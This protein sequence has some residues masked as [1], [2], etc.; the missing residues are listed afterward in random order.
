MWAFRCIKNAEVRKRPE[1]TIIFEDADLIV[2]NK[3]SGLLTM[4][5]DRGDEVTAYSILMDHVRRNDPR[6][7]IFIVHRLDRDTSGLLIFAKNEETKRALQDYWD[8]AVSERIYVAV[9]EGTPSP[10]EGTVVSWLKD[11]PKSFKVSSCPFDNG[12]KKA[13]TH[14]RVLKSNTRYALVEFE[15]ET[16]RKNQIRVHAAVLGHPVAGD[17]KYGAQS[18]PAGRL[19]LHARSIKFKHPWS[20]EI[21]SFNTGIPAKF[22]I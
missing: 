1:I 16:G 4:A 5:T 6:A 15:L 7:R 21:L 3:P 22:L 8:E 2:V 20:G 11:N 14:Y 12:G 17:R 13:V 18:S 19:A 10:A 9:T